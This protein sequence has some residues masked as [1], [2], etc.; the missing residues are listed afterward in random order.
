VTVE[1]E[2]KKNADGDEG[3]N[4]FNGR[5]EMDFSIRTWQLVWWS[6]KTSVR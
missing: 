2:R 3:C 4:C 6:W 1:T 5:L